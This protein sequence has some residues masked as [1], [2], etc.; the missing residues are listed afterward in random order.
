VYPLLDKIYSSKIDSKPHNAFY[1]R[2][3]TL[4]LLPDVNNKRILDAG[5]GP[6]KYAEILIA[7]GGKVTGID[8]SENMIEEA[9][10]RNKGRGSFRIHDITK[11]LDFLEA[12]SIDIIVCPLVLNY[13]KDWNQP[14]REFH[15]VLAP[16][17]LLIISMQHPFFDYL[18]FRSKNYFEV[19]KVKSTWKGFGEPIEVES[20]RKP[21]SHHIND[22][23]A[24]GFIIDKILEPLPSP[25]F[26][27]FDEQGYE[28]LMTFP[29]FMCIR[30]VKK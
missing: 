11:P 28:E 23:T 25:E 22:L 1:D 29:G 26:K 30:T 16:G 27:E 7:R 19:E 5:C 2:P 21:I 17:G 6:G 9:I 14:L 24:N 3:N 18:Y 20:Y 8:L 15:R 13:I 12:G 10:L 4:S